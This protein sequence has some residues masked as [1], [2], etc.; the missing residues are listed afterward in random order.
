MRFPIYDINGHRLYDENGTPVITITGG[1]EIP[2]NL[3]TLI[4]IPHNWGADFTNGIGRNFDI[5]FVNFGDFKVNVDSINSSRIINDI[6]GLNQEQK[7]KL[8]Y[9]IG[10]QKKTS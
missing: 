8:E 1:P 2:K 9:I 6:S 5:P 3:G 10:E 4:N 7:V